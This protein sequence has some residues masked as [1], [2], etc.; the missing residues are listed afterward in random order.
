MERLIQWPYVVGYISSIDVFPFNMFMMISSLVLN[1]ITQ[2]DF[3]LIFPK[4]DLPDI[5]RSI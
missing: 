2:L 5:I 1:E 3:G 4:I